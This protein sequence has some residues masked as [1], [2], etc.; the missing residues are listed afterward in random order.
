MSRHHA[1]LEHIR[2]L[3]H[4]GRFAEARLLGQQVT[5]ADPADSEAARLL[6]EV[7]LFLDDQPKAL[8]FAQRAVELEPDNPG[9]VLHL[10][11]VHRVQR[12]PEKALKVIERAIARIPDVVRLVDIKAAV[13]REMNRFVD[14]VACARQAVARLPDDPSSLA[15]LA[16]SLLNTGRAEEAVA[17]IDHAAAVARGDLAL[18]SSRALFLNYDPSVEPASVF[19]AHRAFGKL[20]DS[21]RGTSTPNCTND[22]SPTRR[23]RVGL[24]SPDLR[25]HSVSHFIEPILEHH[26]RSAIEIVVFYTNRV[27]D[28]VTARL[29]P[30][31]AKW[32]DTDVMSDDAIASRVTSEQI[33][34]L[35]ELS[36]HTH[37]N[38]LPTLHARPAPLQVTYC[39]YPNTTGMTQVDYRIVDSH[40]DPSPAAEALHTERLIRL[41]PCFLCFRP[42]PDSPE[43]AVAPALKNGF[44]TFGSF[45]SIQKISDGLIDAWG[46]VLAAVPRSRLVLKAVNFAD[47]ALRAAVAQRFVDQ[48]IGMERLSLLKPEAVSTNHLAAYA[49]IDIALDPFPYNGTT[50]TCEALWMGVPIVSLAGRSHPGRVGLSL[51]NAVGHPEWVGATVG[52]YVGIAAGLAA[53]VDRLAGI[54]AGLRG[55]VRGSPL[56]D[57]PAFCRR[58]EAA[59]RSIWTAWCG[60]TL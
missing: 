53:D 2:G 13:L 21:V 14:S 12:Q 17:T 5:Q 56:V 48:G 40:T 8:F 7:N 15:T 51:L 32:I 33:D 35:I 11:W 38:C 46:K 52:E 50:T 59:M 57:G 58:F 34:V 6:S 4:T 26:D 49:G 36:G 37:A 9:H 54:R 41:D 3:I 29:K 25:S 30:L 43:P 20:L 22:R 47:D 1:K 39:G 27:R 19:E 28:Q 45:N 42:A 31:A 18:T 55:Q 60:S 24:A 10:A 23:I 16:G 44:V